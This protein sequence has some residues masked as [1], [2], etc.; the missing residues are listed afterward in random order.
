M[1]KIIFVKYLQPV[2]PKLAHEF[3]AWINKVNKHK[4]E[5]NT[6]SHKTSA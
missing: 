2:R 6:K 1:S 3:L 5:S 4:K